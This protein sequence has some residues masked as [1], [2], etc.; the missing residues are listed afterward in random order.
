[1]LNLLL[2][3]FGAGLIVHGGVTLLFE[4]VV[5]AKAKEIKI[6]IDFEMVELAAGI[7]FLVLRG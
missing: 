3:F 4:L 2:L 6:R 7:V 1:M 5:V